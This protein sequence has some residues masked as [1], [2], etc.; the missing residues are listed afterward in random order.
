[1]NP[2]LKIGIVGPCASGKST[3]VTGL[4]RSGWSGKNIAQEHSYVQD[5]WK[6]ISNPDV[7][8]FLEVTYPK[9]IIRKQ[10]SWTEKEF[11][12]QLRRLEHAWSHADLIIFTDLFTTQEVLGNAILFLQSIQ[13]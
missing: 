5:M 12:E 3:L 6:R 9:T 11:R 2:Q 10:L 1:M 7:L 13:H 8:I 4:I